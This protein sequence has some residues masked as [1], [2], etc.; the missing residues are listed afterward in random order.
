[1]HG[2]RRRGVALWEKSRSLA[3]LGMTN[4]EFGRQVFGLAGRLPSFVRASPF[5][6]Q[7]TREGGPYNGVEHLVGVQDG[8]TGYSR[9]MAALA[10]GTSRRISL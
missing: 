6:R 3:L 5:L 8:A 10:E 9:T 2:A 1:M 7:G 4:Q